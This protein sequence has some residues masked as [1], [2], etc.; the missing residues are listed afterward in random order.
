M[1]DNKNKLPKSFRHW[2]KSAGLR[3]NCCGRTKRNKWSAYSLIRRKRHW[4]V[5]CNETFDVSEVY[6]TFDR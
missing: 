6:A 5:N 3:L 2:A 4:R 1:T